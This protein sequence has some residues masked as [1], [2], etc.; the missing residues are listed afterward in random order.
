MKY[1]C[2][3][4][5]HIWVTDALGGD[6]SNYCPMCGGA[7]IEILRR[8]VY[9]FPPDATD[10]E[11]EDEEDSPISSDRTESSNTCDET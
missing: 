8:K 11:F 2:A 7:N 9:G 10:E 6:Y 1:Q 4:C 3:D 5:G